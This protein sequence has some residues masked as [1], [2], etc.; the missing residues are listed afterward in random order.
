MT[1]YTFARQTIPTDQTLVCNFA[2][3][4][5]QYQWVRQQAYEKEVTQ[6]QVIRG[7][8]DREAKRLQGI[9]KASAARK[10]TP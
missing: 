6:T 7:L 9:K 3:T 10:A 8:I 2:L 1:V 5:A 4:M